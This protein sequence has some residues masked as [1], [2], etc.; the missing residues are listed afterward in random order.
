METNNTA[1]SFRDKWHRN[2]D[3][4]FAETLREDS[5]ILRWILERNGWGSLDALR[6]SLRGRGRILDAGCGNGRVTAL[7]RR[8]TDPQ[9]TQVVGVD[10]VSHEVARGNLADAP[11]MQFG[12]ADLTTD[13]TRLGRFD[14]IYCQEV[15]HHTS[16]PAKSF[17]NLCA[18]L[19]PG[20]EIAIYVYKVKAPVRELTD[21]YVRSKIAALP[22]EEAMRLCAQVT[23][24]GKALSDLNAKIRVP[25]VEVLGIEAGEY[26]VQRLIYNAFAKCFWNPELSTEAN[27]LVN[28][29]WYHPQTATR[30]T[31]AEVREW[32]AREGVDIIHEHVDPYG[33][34]VRGVR[35]N[36]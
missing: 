27:D 26:D 30:H 32:F 14:Y 15:L 36:T 1:R 35:A 2:T 25:D 31:L 16:D 20:G 19:Q 3:L 22:Y 13:L 29:D 18:L 9:S 17:G 5:S 6:H 34:T 8:C 10:L 24:L 7:L 12:Q 11:N 28:Y 21:D 33:I 23:Q 4:V